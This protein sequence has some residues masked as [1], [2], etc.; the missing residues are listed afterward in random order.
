M[1]EHIQKVDGLNDPSL[2]SLMEPCRCQC[3]VSRYTPSV[4]EHTA[5]IEIGSGLT[6]RARLTIEHECSQRVLRYSL[7]MLHVDGL[8]E[9]SCRVAAGQGAFGKRGTMD[10]RAGKRQHRHECNRTRCRHSSKG[11]SPDFSHAA[12]PGA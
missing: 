2:S 7:S 8:N 6:Q 4:E 1:T 3:V 9:Q 5:E 11:L 10:A 12:T